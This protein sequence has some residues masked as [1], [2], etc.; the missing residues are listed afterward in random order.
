MTSKRIKSTSFSLKKQLWAPN[1]VTH[2]QRKY[3]TWQSTATRV[4]QLRTTCTCLNAAL[5][6]LY[7][8]TLSE[9]PLVAALS[10]LALVAALATCPI[11]HSSPTTGKDVVCKTTLFPKQIQQ[12]KWRWQQCV[13]IDIVRFREDT[14]KRCNINETSCCDTIWVTEKNWKG[15]GCF[16]S[17]R[18]YQPKKNSRDWSSGKLAFLIDR[19]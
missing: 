18:M 14:C 2:A 5:S 4:S 3:P 7:V 15:R 9:L 19:C 1:F 13:S 8:A 17:I 12:K 10:E 16:R 6:K 11:E